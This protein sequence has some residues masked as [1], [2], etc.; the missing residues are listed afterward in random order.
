MAKI[1]VVGGLGVWLF[2]VLSGFLI[3]RIL[4]EERERVELGETTPM[5][6]LT[7][8]YWRRTIRIFP[9]YYLLLAAIA[10]VAL[11]I[12]IQHGTAGEYLSYVTYTTNLLV[13]HVD[14]WLGSFSHLWS[15]AV[16][17]QFYL[18]FAPLI[19]LT[20]R[21]WSVAICVAL[22]LVGLG[23]KAAM[24]LAHQD[25]TRL[26]VESS[27]NFSIMA[28]GG[29][30]GIAS[31]RPQALSW[32]GRAWV[33]AGLMAA[34][35]LSA[36]VLAFTGTSL[37]TWGTFIPLLCA[38]L[39]I[40]VERGQETWVVAALDLWPLRSLGRVSYGFYLFHNFIPTSLMEKALSHVGVHNAVVTEAMQFALATALA[41][42]S[43]LLVEKPISRLKGGLPR[44]RVPAQV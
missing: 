35:G 27:A 31:L 15:L 13:W 44:P 20:P 25:V 22:L 6:A 34:I 40:G 1:P 41:T 7:Q 30:T 9:I 3:T 24:A 4:I 5:A 16:E 12:P 26:L 33:Q 28:L 36:A 17:E 11:V 19:L 29:L 37:V 43:W 23:V 39:I 21:R 32:T 18:A 2:F 14:H 8:F 10:L 42:A 38:L